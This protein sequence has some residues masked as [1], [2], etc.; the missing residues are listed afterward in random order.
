MK[1]KIH[2]DP[3]NTF[4]CCRT[5]GEKL[6]GYEA[7]KKNLHYYKCHV[8]IG[9]SINANTSIRSNGEGTNNLFQDLLAKHELSCSLKDAFKEK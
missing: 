1:N 5:C 4:I 7:K 2:I 8:C 3:L 9:G 6:T